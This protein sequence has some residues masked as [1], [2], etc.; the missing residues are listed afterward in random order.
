[1]S[2]THSISASGMMLFE[3]PIR[4][5]FGGITIDLASAPIAPGEHRLEIDGGFGGIEIYI[6]RYVEFAIEGGAEL[7]GQDIHDGLGLWE[8]LVNRVRDALRLPKAIPDQAV[9]NPD[10]GKPIKIRMVISNL[11][12]GIDIYRI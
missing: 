11:A 7:G 6:P 3:Q 1:V 4:S 9:A 12:G 2:I 8:W 5:T 10:P